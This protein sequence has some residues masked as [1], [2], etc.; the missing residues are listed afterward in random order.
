M[1]GFYIL[2]KGK[3]PYDAR[4]ADEIER[5][6]RKG[7]PD[8]SAVTDPVA[9]DMLKKMLPANPKERSSAASLLG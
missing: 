2:T 8:L 7:E 5:K 1:L 3:H 9:L 4:A 6:I